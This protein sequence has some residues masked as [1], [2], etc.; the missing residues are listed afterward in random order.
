[1]EKSNY[2]SA[3]WQNN[4]CT[5]I[6]SLGNGRLCV[7]TRKSF[8]SALEACVDALT[9]YH[10]T[11]NNWNCTG[12]GNEAR[13]APDETK[14]TE[15]NPDHSEMLCKLECDSSYVRQLLNDVKNEMQEKGTYTALISL[16]NRTAE[17][18]V[19]ENNIILNDIAAQK[20]VED[21]KKELLQETMENEQEIS[22]LCKQ[23]NKLKE[24]KQEIELKIDR[25]TGYTSAWETAQCEENM[26]RCNI[27]LEYL[28]TSLE[29]ILILKKNEC[30]VAREIDAF[31]KQNIAFNVKASDNW[32]NRYHREMQMYTDRNNQL[33][34]TIESRRS[35]LQELETK[36]RERQEFIDRYLA[37]K[38][39]ARVLRELE[40]HKKQS[41]IWI[42]AWW[43]GVMVRR[44]LGP[45]R[46]D[47]KKKKKTVKGKK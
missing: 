33:R 46:P 23:L 32:D 24:E 4:Q 6:K 35:T 38:E 28:R 20:T 17:K 1:M 5:I 10:Y 31:L 22:G 11:L 42:Q 21:L 39:A 26:K 19:E 34:E 16:I 41:A 36:F 43:R 27:T 30:R 2:H 13:N 7:P 9:I 25:E 8:L 45:Y 18:E 40:E 29:D 3:N 47:E 15:K 12:N 44:K 14:E 37:E